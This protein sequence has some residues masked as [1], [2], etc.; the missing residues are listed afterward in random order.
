MSSPAT[1]PPSQLRKVVFGTA[2]IRARDLQWR[3]PVVVASVV[4]SLT[5]L[6]IWLGEPEAA[7]PLAVGSLFTG[8][9][10]IGE[11]PGHRWRIM[12][13]T[14][15]WVG[16]A[17]V[18][19]GV[20][21]NVGVA[22]LLVVA[23]V[24]AGCG[25]AGALGP[26]G[27]LVGVLTLV[28]YAIYAGVPDTGSGII[29]SGALVGLGSVIQMA[30]LLIPVLVRNRRLLRGREDDL[31]SVRARIRAHSQRRD[32]FMRHGVRLALAMVVAS[33]IGHTSNWPHQYW[34]PMTVAWLSRPDTT[35][36]AT[37]VLSRVAGTI[38]GVAL[39]IAIIDLLGISGYGLAVVV[40]LGAVV[41]LLFLATD[42]T[43]AVIG[44]TVIVMA[45]L[46]LM[47]EQVD[48]TAPSRIASTL[49][50]GVIVVV[51]SV[52][53]PSNSARHAVFE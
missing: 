47:G 28:T 51:A 4:G 20:M 17:S 37:R 52:S 6:A 35:G 12:L 31:P 25:F 15:L 45:L 38:V 14:G 44:I 34:I 26:R 7:F 39:A 30:A 46:S 41:M 23:L 19:G 18:L 40:T 9:G 8:L 11:A 49:V 5:A 29:E 16:L 1:N 2:P 50:A 53:W 27:S 10:G 22:E 21:S 24:G 33:A 13:W 43:V 48:Q 36:M 42:Y 32:D 3:R